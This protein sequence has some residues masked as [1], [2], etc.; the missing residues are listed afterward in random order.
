MTA[1]RDWD[2]ELAEIDRLMAKQPATPPA[3]AGPGKAGPPAPRSGGGPIR[4]V[5]GGSPFGVWLRVLLGAALAAAMTQWPYAHACGLALVLYTGAAGMVVLA[6]LWSA[7]TT[8]R[9][10]L[11]LA[12]VVAL[13]VV[14]WGLAL[15]ASVILPR[16]GYAAER[17]GWLCR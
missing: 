5:A 3:P 4:S 9:S 7:V 17:A 11:G 8:W 14:A 1:P 15:L 13:G 12:H 10:R 2:K 16:I 6:G